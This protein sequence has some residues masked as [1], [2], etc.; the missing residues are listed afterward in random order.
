M[1][2]AA[3]PTWLVFGIFFIQS[4]AARALFQR[5]NGAVSSANGLWLRRDFQQLAFTAITAKPLFKSL[6]AAISKRKKKCLCLFWALGTKFWN[7][8]KK[9]S[10]ETPRA[11]ANLHFVWQIGADEK[12]SR[13][14][15]PTDRS[16]MDRTGVAGG[17]EWSPFRR[18]VTLPAAKI[19]ADAEKWRPSLIW[20]NH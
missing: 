2:Q 6:R 17:A 20:R 9:K 14:G 15:L 7:T 10:S 1:F 8:K 19:A 13:R 18:F 11:S 16:L 4:P 3:P 5:K 12:W